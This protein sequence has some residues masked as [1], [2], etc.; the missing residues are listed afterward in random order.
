MKSIAIL[1]VD[2]AVELLERLKKEAIPVEVHAGAQE[3]GLDFSNILVEDKFYDRACNVAETWTAERKVCR[4]QPPELS[5]PKWKR[6]GFRVLGILF[7]LAAIWQFVIGI[8]DVD[9][10]DIQIVHTY[11]AQ[12][13]VANRALALSFV[14][15]LGATVCFGLSMPNNKKDDNTSA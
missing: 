7:F 13:Y 14:L 2:A 15:V 4:P 10:G 8:N 5:R 9:A 6:M 1:E 11:K 12:S 3:G